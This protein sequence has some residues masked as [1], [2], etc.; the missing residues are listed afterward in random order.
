M[1]LIICEKEIAARRIARI[2]FRKPQRIKFGY[3]YGTTIVFGLKGHIL[4][5]DFPLK[6]KDWSSPLNQL[7]EARL[8][9]KIVDKERYEALRQIARHIDEV[10]IATDYDREG[11]AIGLEALEIIREVNPRVKVRRARF[12]AITYE[13]IRKAFSNLT[14]IDF[15]LANAAFARRELDLLWGAIFTRYVSNSLNK[16]WKEFLSAG[17][18]QTPT[19]ALVVDRE[20]EIRNF[21]PKTYYLITADFGGFLAKG[22]SDEKP[23]L[24][25]EEIAVVEEFNKEIDT[26]PQPLPFNTTSFL[27]DAGKLG[28]KPHE[29]MRIAE[30][31]YMRGYISYPRTDNTSLSKV[32]VKMIVKMLYP[33][34]KYK[35][36]LKMRKG[37][38]TKDH[39]PI[40]PTAPPKNLKGDWLKIY[41]LI[42]RRFLASVS[43]PA[44]VEVKR[45]N[46]DIKGYKLQAKGVKIVEK[47]WLQIYGKLSEEFLPDL[48]RGQRLK[49]RIK[50]KKEKTKPPP[51]YNSSTLVKRMEALGLGTKSTRAEIIRKLFSRKYIDEK[52]RPSEDAFKVIEL[53]REKAKR[54]TS[55]ELT[56][57]LEEK[58]KKVEKG[59]LS[60]EELIAE[61]KEELRKIVSKL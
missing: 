46:F 44:K 8:Y 52:F 36:A 13:E 58:L 11:E 6:L 9:R 28:F 22:K 45:A 39:P 43:S 32:N 1:R 4:D 41:D 3:K 40:H 56:A 5:V 50:V 20:T 2:L 51:R 29:S 12:S 24:A 26:L 18:V 37:K 61:A 60:K 23:E 14:S 34:Y 49:A 55:P 47:G 19:L 15:N 16:K 30:E 57:N 35:P 7:I 17:R 38:E 21:I 54:I 59:L 10:I 42:A 33:Y 25:D 48:Q 31:L 27:A 53:L